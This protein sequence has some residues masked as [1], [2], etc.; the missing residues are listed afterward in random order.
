[1]FF[2]DPTFILLIPA[3]ILAIW[4]QGKL[5]RT[6]SEFS[7]VRS[8]RGYSGAKVARQILDSNGLQSVTIERVQGNLSD[9]YDPR[10]RKLRLSSGVYGSDSIAAIGV[11]AH[12]VG[13]AIQHS[14]GYV[15]LNVRNAII[16]VVNLG[17]FAAWP[18]FIIGFFLRAPILIQLGIILFA[19]AVLFQIVTLPV[20][21]NASNRALT[22]L[23]DDGYLSSEETSG[24]K[25]VLT[26]AAMTY[27]ASTAM[28]VTQLL[29]MLLLSR[30]S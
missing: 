9:H 23:Q 24:A 19:G 22:I 13:H 14:R 7:Q 21:F 4:A 5:K 25:K 29:R 16:P 28:A 1:M 10:S 17:S 12:E 15:P 8:S 2:W 26:A 3:L 30:R 11:A 18:M 6:F 27:V 20:E